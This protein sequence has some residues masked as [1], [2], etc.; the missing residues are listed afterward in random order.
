MESLPEEEDAW[1][2]KTG[3]CRRTRCH[4]CSNP[5]ACGAKSV[6][7][8]S[9]DV[10]VFFIHANEL[11][12]PWSTRSAERQN[13]IDDVVVDK[14]RI[15]GA[16]TTGRPDGD[17]EEAGHSRADGE[18]GEKTWVTDDRRVDSRSKEDLTSEGA[19]DSEI[20]NFWEEGLLPIDLTRDA[21]VACRWRKYAHSPGT[22]GYR[23]CLLDE[24]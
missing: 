10:G 9:G 24:E 13:S 2:E 3:E 8:V 18:I 5:E 15:R 23:R 21:L 17:A 4:G 12:A 19:A 14:V 11:Y 7:Q 22:D 16:E 1:C 6:G 20:V